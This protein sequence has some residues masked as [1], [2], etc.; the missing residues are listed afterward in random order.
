M[1]FDNIWMRNGEVDVNLAAQPHVFRLAQL[2]LVKELH[3]IV[4]MRLIMISFDNVRV[5]T[6]EKENGEK[7]ASE[8]GIR[9]GEKDKTKQESQTN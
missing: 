1:N 6:S 7:S 8:V 9:T 5:A 3:C 2:L 4:N